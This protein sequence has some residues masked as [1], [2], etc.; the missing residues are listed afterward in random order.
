MLIAYGTHALR[1]R[2]ILQWIVYA[3][4]L[5]YRFA[6]V[7]TYQM[8]IH[9]TSFPTF[10]PCEKITLPP[11]SIVKQYLFDM[12]L[13]LNYL[14]SAGICVSRL[15]ALALEFQHGIFL[16]MQ[17]LN[18]F[19]SCPGWWAGSL[20]SSRCV[21]TQP[22]VVT[23]TLALPHPVPGAPALASPLPRGAEGLC[24]SLPRGDPAIQMR[25]RRNVDEIRFAH[26]CLLGNGLGRKH[27]KQMYKLRVT[28]G[29]S[30]AYWLS[31]HIQERGSGHA[32]HCVCSAETVCVC[33][34][35]CAYVW[36]CMHIYTYLC[37]WR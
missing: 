9:Q 31:Q 15:L 32:A 21:N 5:L 7:G 36:V 30:L 10:Y 26:N 27:K 28:A 3:S 29:I 18:Y 12:P 23:K 2:I 16:E 35:V 1:S 37:A 34:C 11:F 22:L 14:T 19:V 4:E 25:R 17:F 13:T 8:G 33:V 20:C 24:S 6:Y